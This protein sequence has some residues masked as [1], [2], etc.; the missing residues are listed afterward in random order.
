MKAKTK[1][2]ALRRPLAEPPQPSGLPTGS[3]LL[4]DQAWARIAQSLK[5]SARELEIVRFDFDNLT[6]ATIAANLRR[7]P[8]TIHS[9]MN[10][11]FKKL[12][13]TTRTQLA[14]RVFQE[15]MALTLSQMNSLPPICPD[16]VAGRCPLYR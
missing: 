6:D 15:F 10:R 8:H 4:S 1:K 5:L 7:S 9:H 2:R 3:A 12:G 14:V 11:L 13:V 16:R